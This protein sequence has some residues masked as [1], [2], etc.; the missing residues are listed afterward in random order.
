MPF[1][2]CAL[3]PPMKTVKLKKKEDRRILRGHPWVFSNELERSHAECVPGDLVEVLDNAG[4]FIGRGTIN[5]HTLIAVR[6][7]TRIREEIDGDFFK[8][9]IAQARALR[10]MLGYG[11][12]F[13]AV[14]S[15]GDE[16]P[17]LIVDKYADTLVVQSSTAG[18][19][20]VLSEVLEALQKEYRPRAIVLRNDVS[21]RETE[22]LAQE[23]R[24]VHGTISGPVMFEESGI[25]YRVDVLEGQKTGFFFDQ[26]EN[27]LALETYVRG[28]RMLDCFCYVGA[29]ALSATRFGAS[30]VIGLDSSEKA[31]ELA[32]ENATLNSLA[33]QFKK[34]DVFDELRVL[35]KQRERFG[36]I[37]LDPP[38]FVK[39]RAKVRE[40]LKGYKEINLRAMKLLEPG[41]ALV[42]CS[43][44][45][46]IDQELFR[47][48]LIN[49]A[50]SAGR[51]TK[52]MEMRSQARDH[53]ALLAARE[54]QY[55]KCAILMVE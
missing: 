2:L 19:D 10:T 18:I 15:E 49:A 50:Y 55:L 23:T 29:W 34:A 43:C 42:T 32:T 52:L 37:I 36:C 39:S 33:A 5:P 26:R 45:H 27:R 31:I 48:M 30:E 9:R 16:L 25:K 40:A 38:A 51:Q 8:R 41:G 28:R 14:F 12:S 35:E 7:F 44:S 20:R 1:A 53:P 24:I 46:H 13:R 54:T 3:P 47:E 22:G 4:H 17:G 21:S 11:D 6:L